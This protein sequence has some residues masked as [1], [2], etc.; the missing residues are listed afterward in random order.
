[1]GQLQGNLARGDDW[2]STMTGWVIHHDWMISPGLA[3]KD[4]NLWNFNVSYIHYL[5][6]ITTKLKWNWKN[7]SQFC[8]V[9]TYSCAA[10]LVCTINLSVPNVKRSIIYPISNPISNFSFLARLVCWG[11]SSMRSAPPSTPRSAFGCPSNH[12]ASMQCWSSWTNH[13]WMKNIPFFSKR[14]CN[15]GTQWAK[16]R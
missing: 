5:S 6:I 2:G 8:R 16:K 4:R 1:M 9:R 13:V 10:I 12:A 3:I 14:F 7:H 15:V 11:C